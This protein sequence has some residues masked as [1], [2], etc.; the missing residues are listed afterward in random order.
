MNIFGK[1]KKYGV[2]MMTKDNRFT[3]IF[4]DG[5]EMSHP[6]NKSTIDFVND[7]LYDYELKQRKIKINKIKSK[8]N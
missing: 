2:Q 1:L 5:T 6:D 3:M 8:L 4:R 7:S